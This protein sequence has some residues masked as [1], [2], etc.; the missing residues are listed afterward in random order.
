MALIK[1]LIFSFIL[2]IICYS[3]SIGQ[4]QLKGKV[5]DSI[6]NEPLFGSTV[7][8]KELQIGQNIGLDGSFHFRKIPNGVYTVIFRNSTYNQNTR[9]LKFSDD[10]I[11]EL[12]IYMSLKEEMLSDVVITARHDMESERYALHREK[13]SENIINVMSSKA[14]E[15][16]P[17]ITTASVLQRVSGI[18]LEKTSTGDA[19]YAVIRGMDQRYNYTLVNGIK[20]PS[21]DNKYRYVP[22]DMFPSELLERLEVIKALTPN[23]EGDA[24]GGAMNLIMKNAPEK[25]TINMNVG[26]GFSQLLNQR[27]YKN[28]DRSTVNPMSP[29]DINGENYQAKPS[30]F[31]YKNFDYASKNNPVNSLLGFSV[32]SRFLKRKKLGVVLAAS[33]QNLYR[34]SNTLWFKPEN[35]PAPGN[36][37]AF[38]DVYS[39]Q[40]NTQQTRIGIHTKIDY[41]FNDKHKVSLYNLYMQMDETQYRHTVDTSLSIG[42]SGV[43]TGNTYI[44]DR[45]RMQNQSIY[46]S[47]LQGEHEFFNHFKFKWSG[48][49]SIA[50]SETP[51]WS[52]V[53]TVH[54]VG[55]D[56]QGNQTKT[57]E[58]LNIPF[59]RIWTRN[60]DRDY[61]AYANLSYKNKI[62]KKDFEITT[63][64]LYRDK[65]RSNNYNQWNLVPKTSSIGLAIPFDGNLSADKFQ[66]NGATAAQGSP[67]NPL[68]YTATENIL[69]YY[70]MI[71]LFI[72]KNLSVLGGLRVE[73][74]EQGWVTVLDPKVSYGAYGKI[75]YTDYLP[76]VHFKYRINEKQNLRLSYF[77]AINRPGFFEYIPFT[78]DSDDFT[79]SGNPLLKHATS[80]NYDLRYEFFPKSLDQLLIGGFYKEIKNPIET[81]I[82][83]TG[84]SSATLK[85]FNFGSAVNFGFELAF[86][87]YWGE[88]GVSGNYT[89]TNSKITTAKLFYDTNFV[90]IETTQVRPLQ[91]Q[92]P[93]IA[94]LSVLYKSK[95]IGLDI[96]LAGVYT[97]RKIS[98]VSPYKDLDYWQRGMFQLDLSIEKKVFKI[99]SIYLK[100][101]NLLNTPVFVEILQPNIYTTGKFALTE[102][103]RT[104]R[105]TV[106]KDYYGQTFV[107]GIRLKN[108]NFKNKNK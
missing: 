80:Q 64:I 14:I 9:V 51:D 2:L 76:S 82:Q 49:Y 103:T 90:A 71:D 42:R 40:Y 39:R 18:T 31:T 96:Q 66:F 48:V 72:T 30:D 102:Q 62:F 95:S 52:E 65:N 101:S 87:K 41:E 104:D 7:Y 58:V 15:L 50:K 26:G 100:A 36:I 46:N 106:Q 79:I 10:E 89:Y 33:Y 37:P 63:G 53:Q 61:A 68:T 105:V 4:N 98:L 86:T 17:D 55:F 69:A 19:R 108:F 34:G 11:I 99:F 47:T 78:I 43:G 74:T 45:S 6:S 5:L 44:L 81:A 97:G 22:M 38:T 28:F 56:A 57:P 25:F 94:N 59:Y 83:F 70:G 93:H 1:R 27:G 85:P 54:V 77:S 73:Q 35:Q 12:N 21:P 3:Y 13:N 24:I 23:L 67:K 16:L 8:I 29:A 107:F 84:T 91:G 75:P 60:T 88:L 92:S 20:I 32:G